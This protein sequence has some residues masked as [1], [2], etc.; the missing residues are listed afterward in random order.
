MV[1]PLVKPCNFLIILGCIPLPTA[2]KNNTQKQNLFHLLSLTISLIIKLLNIY[3]IFPKPDDSIWKTPS[4]IHTVS[5]S[6]VKRG[7]TGLKENVLSLPA[8]DL[9]YQLNSATFL[10]FLEN[11]WY[12]WSLS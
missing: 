4:N 7:K 6:V 2:L 9:F 5:K 10:D 11:K 8:R 3:T 12:T 1:I